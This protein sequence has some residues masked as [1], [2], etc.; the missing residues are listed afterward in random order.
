[1]LINSDYMNAL[2]KRYIPH[3]VMIGILLIVCF[4]LLV[5]MVVWVIYPIA[6]VA[7]VMLFLLGVLALLMFYEYWIISNEH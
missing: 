7:V 5:S 6:V 2:K 4:S 1:M 3:N